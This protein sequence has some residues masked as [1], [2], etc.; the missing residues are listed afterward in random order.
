M[1]T[2]QTNGKIYHT[3]GLEELILLKWAHYPRQ[4]TD[5][6]Q[7]PI[8]IWMAFFIRTNYSKIFMETQ[9]TLN[10]NLVK[11]EQSWEYHA[12]WFQAIL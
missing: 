6:M 1:K 3:H 7:F 2:T 8:K 4:S 10:S 9:K 5:S 11:K 12:S